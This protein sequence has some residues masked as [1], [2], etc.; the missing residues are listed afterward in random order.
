SFSA[1][2]WPSINMPLTTSTPNSFRSARIGGLSASTN[3]ITAMECGCRSKPSSVEGC[4]VFGGDAVQLIIVSLPLLVEFVP[5]RAILIRVHPKC[6]S[7]H[8][9]CDGAVYGPFGHFTP[10]A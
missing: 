10:L 9:L 6:Y 2:R 7:T 3:F 1:S 8:R 4:G 5:H